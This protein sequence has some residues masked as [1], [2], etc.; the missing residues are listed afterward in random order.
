M[1]D[2]I[3]GAIVLTFLALCLYESKDSKKKL[4]YTTGQL[5]DNME[6][7]KAHLLTRIRCM[8]FVEESRY[9]EFEIRDFVNRFLFHDD[10]RA[11]KEE[12]KSELQ[13]QVNYL[14]VP[15]LMNA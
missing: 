2:F 9:Y 12:L 8:K 7:Q 3:T 14:S 15:Q 6:K 1:T 13:A 10:I 5:H 11:A 4:H